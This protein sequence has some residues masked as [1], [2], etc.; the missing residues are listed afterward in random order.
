MPMCEIKDHKTGETLK[1]YDF[2]GP[3]VYYAGTS[4][5]YAPLGGTSVSPSE[6]LATLQPL[7]ITSI[8]KP[9]WE[10]TGQ[11]SIGTANWRVSVVDT[12][13]GETKDDVYP[14]NLNG[15]VYELECQPGT[16]VM[17][18]CGGY[19]IESSWEGKK[20]DEIYRLK[21]T[22][23]IIY[24]YDRIIDYTVHWVAKNITG[25]YTYY[26]GSQ[27]W[28]LDMPVTCFKA[29]VNY[30]YIY[31][32]NHYEQIEYFSHTADMMVLEDINLNAGYY[33]T[34]QPDKITTYGEA[35]GITMEYLLNLADNN[36]LIYSPTGH[37]IALQLA[38]W[39]ERYKVVIVEDIISP[40]MD[41]LG[42]GFG[43][44]GVPFKKTWGLPHAFASP[45]GS[46]YV[47]RESEAIPWQQ[48]GSIGS[49][50][51]TH[52]KYAIVMKRFI[53]LGKK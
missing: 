4:L 39:K 25:F 48:T 52:S 32:F 40:T 36:T 15:N 12:L 7:G 35:I 17:A 41:G 26:Y 8:M 42:N 46:V 10:V 44:V 51:I 9:R 13:T 1:A 30:P 29:G 23:E 43:M 34:Y 19:K 37:N 6:H 20:S 28:S 45:G 38:Y 50:Y 27:N 22:W 49:G 14:F 53:L 21:D 2:G 16:W 24:S 3:E 18:S 5:V 31:T 47:S 33:G 11:V